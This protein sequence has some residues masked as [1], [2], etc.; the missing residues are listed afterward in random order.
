MKSL[1]ANPCRL[2]A[3][4]KVLRCGHI[5]PKFYW[6]WLKQTGSGY[7]RDFKKPNVKVQ[8]GHKLY[9]LCHECEE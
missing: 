9:L 2:C 1:P 8:D 4:P 3:K 7:F 6:D 5:F